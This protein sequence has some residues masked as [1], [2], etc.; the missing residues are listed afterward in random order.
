MSRKRQSRKNPQHI[1]VNLD[2]SH[3]GLDPDCPICALLAVQGQE[4]QVFDPGTMDFTPEALMP[5]GPVTTITL[6]GDA[7][8]APH[9]DASPMELDVPKGMMVGEFLFAVRFAIPELAKAFPEGGLALQVDGHPLGWAA[10]VPR[11]VTLVATAR[12]SMS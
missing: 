3:G 7:A 11:A 9:L 1:I 4:A 6:T 5:M 12:Q 8:V 2:G 10:P